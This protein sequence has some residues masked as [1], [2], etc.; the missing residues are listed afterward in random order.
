MQTKI[1]SPKEQFAASGLPEPVRGGG[2][3]GTEGW[4]VFRSTSIPELDGIR[5]YVDYVGSAW[6]APQCLA[7]LKS[8]MPKSQYGDWTFEDFRTFANY[9]VQMEKLK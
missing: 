8:L 7:K 6:I 2:H 9:P 5:F 1:A 4:A 3:M